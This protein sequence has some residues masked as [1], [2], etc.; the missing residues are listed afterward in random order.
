MKSTSGRFSA[1]SA[2]A[3]PRPA[4]SASN[5][6]LYWLIRSAVWPPVS[7]VSPRYITGLCWC[8]LRA[9][10]MRW[11]LWVPT[12]MSLEEG[13]ASVMAPRLERV[14]VRGNPLQHAIEAEPHLVVHASLAQIAREL[15]V[16]ATGRRVRVGERAEVRVGRAELAGEGREGRRDVAPGVVPGD[17]AVAEP[18]RDR[19]E[20]AEVRR[21]RRRRRR[22]RLERQ[23]VVHDHAAAEPC[24]QL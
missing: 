14:S 10:T 11:P 8:R 19:A 2:P 4:P 12:R 13:R 5:A 15:L 1:S 16:E 7:V 21:H 17:A 3:V 18:A 20:V 24:E 6:W 9:A 22:D 23:L